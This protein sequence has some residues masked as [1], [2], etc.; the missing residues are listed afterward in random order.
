MLKFSSFIVAVFSA[1]FFFA[2]LVSTT[3][4]GRYTLTAEGA[5]YFAK[6]SLDCTSKPTP[7]YYYQALRQPG[8][9]QTPTDI[10]PSFYGCYD[11]HSAVHNHWAL[12]KI[13]KT[14]LIYQK[15]LLFAPSSMKVSARRTSAKNTNISKPI[16]SVMYLN[17][18]TDRAGCLR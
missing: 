3:P 2:Q 10:W 16:R 7:H 5:S 15:Q 6:L 17:F 14:Y 1:G 13:L 9:T 18:L 12:I 4:D 8:D 11:W